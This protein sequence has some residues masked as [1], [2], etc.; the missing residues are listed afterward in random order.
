MERDI[1]VLP[2]MTEFAGSFN[3]FGIQFVVSYILT[4]SLSDP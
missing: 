3:S 1:S 4:C 2:S